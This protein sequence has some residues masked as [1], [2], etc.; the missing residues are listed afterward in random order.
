MPKVL[1]EID[2]E[3]YTQDEK[4][5]LLLGEKLEKAPSDVDA[6]Y[7][8]KTTKG[9]WYLPK[10][11]R[12]RMLKIK[13]LEKQMAEMDGEGFLR[14]IADKIKR[15]GNKAKEVIRKE[16]SPLVQKT[17]II[18][19]NR[20]RKAYPSVLGGPCS[21]LYP[22]ELHPTIVI[23]RPDGTKACL[24]YRFCGPGTNLDKR[25][26]DV[27][28]DEIDAIAKEHD[29]AYLNATG[30]PNEVELKHKADVVMINALDS[31]GLTNQPIGKMARQLILGKMNAEQLLQLFGKEQALF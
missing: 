27:P 24:D 22:G 15:F 13:L 1:H 19:S 21:L 9:L 28:C 23:T 10:P 17:F 31:K 4:I 12:V 3:S 8:K 5:Q 29:Y 25:K 30:R 20:I 2:L 26:N 6:K 11:V 14:N 16:V 7:V 18:A